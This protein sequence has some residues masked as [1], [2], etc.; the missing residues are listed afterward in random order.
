MFSIQFH[1]R[2]AL[3]VSVYL[4]R[5]N[6]DHNVLAGKIPGRRILTVSW[7]WESSPRT[8]HRA[9]SVAALTCT[10]IVGNFS[11]EGGSFPIWL[12]VELF[13]KT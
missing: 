10:D 8:L 11:R 4:Y 2:H 13:A 1:Q 7:P 5:H 9:S 3:S 12:G 6:T